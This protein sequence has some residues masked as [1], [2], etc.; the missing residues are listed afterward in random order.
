[1]SVYYCRNVS[2]EYDAMYYKYEINQNYVNYEKD[3]G[4]II[5]KLG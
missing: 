3:R 1:M 5:G 2:G 4:T